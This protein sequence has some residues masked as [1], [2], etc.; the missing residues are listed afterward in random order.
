MILIA[1]NEKNALKAGLSRWKQVVKHQIQY[2]EGKESQKRLVRKTLT[3]IMSRRKR[4]GFERWIR[5]RDW[6]R[7]MERQKLKASTLIC[8]RLGL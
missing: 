2:E 6:N 8:E 3:N 4:F 5:Y 7:K 1:R